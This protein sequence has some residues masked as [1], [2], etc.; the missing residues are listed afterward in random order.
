MFRRFALLFLLGAMI[1]STAARADINACGATIEGSVYQDTNQNGDRDPGEEGMSAIVRLYTDF[2][3]PVG[4]MES[5]KL[6]AAQGKYLFPVVQTGK[7]Y[8]VCVSLDS[9]SIQTYP[10]ASNAHAVPNIG[11]HGPNSGTPDEGEYCWQVENPFANRR[12]GVH[13]FPCE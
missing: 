12:F 5:G 13:T 2:W 10:T 8:F 7:T 11:S 9:C 1:I 6:T 4:E 3:G